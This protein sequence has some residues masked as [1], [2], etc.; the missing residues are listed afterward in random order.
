MYQN[1]KS[2]KGTLIA[3]Y[4][5]LA[6]YTVKT[7]S[8]TNDIVSIVNRNSITV[9][10][11]IDEQGQLKSYFLQAP[12]EITCTT[13]NP[14]V[15]I[16]IDNKS[17]KETKK[18]GVWISIVG[19]NKV[20]GGTPTITIPPIPPK[21]SIEVSN[22]GNGIF[23]KTIANTN[24]TASIIP[25]IFVDFRDIDDFSL[26]HGI[27]MDLTAYIKHTELSVKK[28]DASID[29]GGFNLGWEIKNSGC[30]TIIPF[31]TGIY[32]SKDNLL[33][34][35][36]ILMALR[37]T[38]TLLQGE[39]KSEYLAILGNPNQFLDF[40]Y[41]ILKVDIQNQIKETN[42]IDNTAIFKIDNK[43]FVGI[44]KDKNVIVYPKPF[45][46]D[47]NFEVITNQQQSLVSIS[48]YNQSGILEAIVISNQNYAAG[49]HG[50]TSS[51][52]KLTPGIYFYV[53]QIDDKKSTGSLIKK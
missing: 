17:N 29:E 30:A 10:A 35:K 40:E 47:V 21:R 2:I 11:I 27:S 42:E 31:L 6:S 37:E 52:G 34:D 20:F 1:L 39:N 12:K 13:S 38:P 43:N 28:V 9:K 51:L 44:A 3:T 50:I 33:D 7:Y 23:Y 5:F 49:K 46:D 25:K 41:V 16:I 14:L 15:K 53:V 36:D 18:I 26:I 8:Q 48:I 32:A 19:M 22:E 4:L 45:K 24:S